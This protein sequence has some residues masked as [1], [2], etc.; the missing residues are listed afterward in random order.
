MDVLSLLSE[1]KLID[2]GAIAT[3][4][5]EVASGRKTLERALL[6]RGVSSGDIL[7]A[8]GEYYQIPARTVGDEGSVPFEVLAYVPEESARHYRFAPIAVSDGV[9]EIGTTDPDNL[10]ATEALNFIA[11]RTNLPYKLFLI[12]DEDFD[13]VIGM[14]KGL[15]GEV[16]KALT[17]LETTIQDES[18][19]SSF[20]SS[21]KPE[22]PAAGAV[23]R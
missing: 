11:G 4:K 1:K 18:I 9:L 5:E 3:I 8:R 7:S 17:E 19:A 20:E 22:S 2:V 14:Y 6:D 21:E 15:T 16:G 12:S 10:E 23:T 13:K